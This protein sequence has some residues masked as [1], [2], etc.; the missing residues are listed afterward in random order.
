MTTRTGPAGPDASDRGKAVV[1]LGRIG[2][3]HGVQGWVKVLSYTDPVAGI[4]GYG[5]WT[6]LQGGQARQVQ[7]K[8]SKRAGQM[9]AVKL[10]G[11]DTVDAARMLNG[12]EV[13]VDRS[14]LAP[15][16]PKEHYL[17]DLL[18]LDAVNR[19]GIPLGRVDELIDMPAHPLLV[20]RDGKVERL[21]PL[22]RERLIAVDLDAGRVTVDWH[23][24]D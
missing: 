1:V 7:V 9:L 17:H 23:P 12:A 24:D 6:L 10:E 14:A 2:A 4:A 11:V 13:Q 22:V 20:L 16:G 8:D 19:D 3:P 5:Q 15:T 21:V 18:G